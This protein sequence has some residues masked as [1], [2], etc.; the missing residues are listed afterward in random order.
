MLIFFVE[1]EVI[2]KRSSLYKIPTY[3]LEIYFQ[4]YNIPNKAL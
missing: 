1:I 3:E 2:E 4:F